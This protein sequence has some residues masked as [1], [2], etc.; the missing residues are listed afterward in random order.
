MKL[1][2]TVTLKLVLAIDDRNNYA[3][4]I[5]K[6][7]NATYSSM[8]KPLEELKSNNIIETYKDGRKV[9]IKLTEKGKK[10]QESLKIIEDLI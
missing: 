5:S 1:L 2:S 8:Y 7:I 10:I 9:K 3:L 4:K 6:K